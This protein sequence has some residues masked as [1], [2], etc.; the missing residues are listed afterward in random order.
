M[1]KV[2]TVLSKVPWRKVCKVVGVATLGTASVLGAM[3]TDEN[4]QKMMKKV[5]SKVVK[6]DIEPN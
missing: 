3:E 4:T 6:K 5:A 1:N 2:V